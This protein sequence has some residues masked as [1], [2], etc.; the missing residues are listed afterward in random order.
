MLLKQYRG[1]LLL[2]VLVIAMLYNGKVD[3]DETM[4]SQIVLNVIIEERHFL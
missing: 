3:K 1:V 2:S 4:T